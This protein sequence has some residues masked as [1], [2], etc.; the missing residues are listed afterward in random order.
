MKNTLRQT[1]VGG[2]GGRRPKTIRPVS[3][4]TVIIGMPL[5]LIPI[6]LLILI[7]L[8]LI[9]VIVI[10]PV[11]FPST[12]HVSFMSSYMISGLCLLICS[13][14]NF[15]HAPAHPCVQ[16]VQL[17]QSVRCQPWPGAMC[18][19]HRHPLRET[20]TERERVWQSV[21][22][23]R[24]RVAICAMCEQNAWLFTSRFNCIYVQRR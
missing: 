20:A 24:G 13:H 21:S 7:M 4:A 1:L 5:M 14:N 11:S 18:Q 2:R 12:H 9:I 19:A 23:R 8:I 17:V 3:Q 15:F 16:R 10:N 22:K 6:V